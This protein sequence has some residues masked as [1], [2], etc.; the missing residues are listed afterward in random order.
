MKI[1]IQKQIAFTRADLIAV[2]A[3][4]AVLGLLTLPLRGDSES[5]NATI[6]CRTNK[7]Q[8][9]RALHLYTMDNG[10]FLPPNGGSSQPGFTW[11][12][13]YIDYAS[14]EATN[15]TILSNPGTSL[16]ANYLERNPRPFKCP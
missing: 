1:T 13:G 11:V 12:S 6:I 16:L 8:L 4:C 7:R 3:I 9:I 14:A 2:V 15:A 5:E 10:G